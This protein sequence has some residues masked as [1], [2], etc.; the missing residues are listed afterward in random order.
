MVD[1]S[2]S[3]QFDCG[4]K[5]ATVGTACLSCFSG[6]NCCFYVLY[7]ATCNRNVLFYEK[8]NQHVKWGI[9]PKSCCL[10]VWYFHSDPN[11]I[12]ISHGPWQC[13]L[14]VRHWLR[15]ITVHEW[16]FVLVTLERLTNL[17]NWGTV[18]TIVHTLFLCQFPHVC[19]RLFTLSVHSYEFIVTVYF[20]PNCDLAS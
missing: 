9:C 3:Q 16:C 14:V 18:N 12:S 10:R 11:D 2:T 19:R 20:I 15:G 13:P 8:P 5:N 4:F 6:P 7:I 1:R 17:C